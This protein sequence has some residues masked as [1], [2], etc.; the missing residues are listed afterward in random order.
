MNKLINELIINGGF[1]YN[2]HNDKILHNNK[3]YYV[4]IK[5]M[6]IVDEKDLTAE[7]FN[8]IISQMI[9]YAENSKKFIGVWHNQENKKVY[10]DY[11]RRYLS[12]DKALA[13]GKA[14]NQINIFDIERGNEI[15]C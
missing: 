2:H 4:R 8:L 1:T 10:F 6:Y 7:M 13:V 14:H 3:G 12:L 11:S 15:K 5:D 9:D